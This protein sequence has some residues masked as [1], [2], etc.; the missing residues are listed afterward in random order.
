MFGDLLNWNPHIT[1]HQPDPDVPVVEVS[2]AVPDPIGS[3]QRV[4]NPPFVISRPDV[5]KLIVEPVEIH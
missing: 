1:T 4:I 5:Q 2:F 3:L